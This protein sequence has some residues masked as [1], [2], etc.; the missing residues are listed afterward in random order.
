MVG[1]SFDAPA[2]QTSLFSGGISQR[3]R[4]EDSRGILFGTQEK[5]RQKMQQQQEQEQAIQ[6]QGLSFEFRKKNRKKC[7]TTDEEPDDLPPSRPPKPRKYANLGAAPPP[8]SIIR[9]QQGTYDVPQIPP[10]PGRPVFPAA[11]TLSRSIICEQERT[12]DYVPPPRRATP[13]MASMSSKLHEPPTY[14]LTDITQPTY[15]VAPTNY[16]PTSYDAPPPPPQLPCSPPP[17]E[18]LYDVPNLLTSS[19]N[20]PPPP[21]PLP[22]ES[23]MVRTKSFPAKKVVPELLGRRHTRGNY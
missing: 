12:Y 4:Q 3:S 1:F 2:G 22:R 19:K 21:P 18:E 10:R 8:S 14:S 23:T 17:L 5:G 11:S 20:A 6:S 13:R 7:K 16:L 15:D 9:D